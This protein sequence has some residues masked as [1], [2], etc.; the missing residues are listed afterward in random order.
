MARLDPTTTVS[1][2]RSSL[3][4]VLQQF[5]TLNV[6]EADRDEEAAAGERA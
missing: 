3:T 6:D 2:M 4:G 5:I 1:K